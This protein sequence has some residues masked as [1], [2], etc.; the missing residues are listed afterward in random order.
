MFMI[1]NKKGFGKYEVLTMIVILLAIFA[2]LMYALLGG[3]NKQKFE[4]FRDNAITFSKTS[5]TNFSSFHNFENVYLNEVVEEELIKK[6]RSPFS[7]NYC[8]EMESKVEMIDGQPYVT[9]KCD[10]YLIDKSKTNSI[11]SMKIYKVGEWSEKQENK[12]DEKKT[13]YNCKKDGKEMFDDYMEELQMVS[14]INR[15]HE[16]DFY[17]SSEVKSVCDV[18]TKDFYR[19]KELISE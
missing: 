8:D 15:E 12:N 11:S 17:F 16:T 3:V 14:R 2:Y 4:T 9:L 7:T 6:I 18:V 5:V 13:L 19:T 1:N 10:D